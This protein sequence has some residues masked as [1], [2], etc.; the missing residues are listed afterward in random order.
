MWSAPLHAA[1]HQLRDTSAYGHEEALGV[2]LPFA[3]REQTQ[4][5]LGWFHVAAPRCCSSLLAVRHA[6]NCDQRVEE[7]VAQVFRVE[8]GNPLAGFEARSLQHN[9][10][11]VV[12][13]SERLDAFLNRAADHAFN[14]A[15]A[16]TSVAL[17]DVDVKGAALEAQEALLPDANAWPVAGPAHAVCGFGLHVRRQ[18]RPHGRALVCGG[19][20]VRVEAAVADPYVALD[21][22]DGQRDAVRVRTGGAEDPAA[23]PAVVLPTEEG[24][25]RHA[26]CALGGL[27]VGRPLGAWDDLQRHLMPCI[28]ET[29][30]KRGRASARHGP[31]H[32]AASGKSD[33]SY[34]DLDQ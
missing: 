20:G 19:L 33:S 6:V 13:E 25:G 2:F 34:G 11:A 12:R 4:Q 14:G 17:A 28:Q 31:E 5:R 21:A 9:R 18:R 30:V 7:A 1:G 29:Q 22:I 8:R 26:L 27:A 10:W 15:V 23:D 32:H 16:D 24:E 3:Q